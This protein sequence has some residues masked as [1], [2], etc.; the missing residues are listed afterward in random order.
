MNFGI[1]S[2]VG[3]APRD[4]FNDGLGSEIP[5]RY[6]AVVKFYDSSSPS[7]FTVKGVIYDSGKVFFPEGLSIDADSTFIIAKTLSRHISSKDVVIYKEGY[8]GNFSSIRLN[9]HESDSYIGAEDMKDAFFVMAKDLSLPIDLI[10]FRGPPNEGVYF[11]RTAIESLSL[12]NKNKFLDFCYE[13][14]KDT[15]NV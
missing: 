10:E 2:C 8:G 7:V 13:I 6:S 11:N 3:T 5:V 14:M 12:P 1:L 9:N 15:F 4:Y